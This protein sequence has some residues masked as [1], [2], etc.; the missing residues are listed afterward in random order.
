MASTLESFDALLLM[1][2]A[3]GV[4]TRATRVSI[5]DTTIVVEFAA[6]PAPLADPIAQLQ[7]E[8]RRFDAEQEREIAR[9]NGA[10]G[11]FRARKLPPV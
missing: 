5:H 1:L 8:Q 2:E 6:A 4:L 11:G 10:V 9:R 3:R 7:S